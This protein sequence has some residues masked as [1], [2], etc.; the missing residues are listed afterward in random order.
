MGSTK[1]VLYP[2]LLL[3]RSGPDPCMSD[4][5]DGDRSDAW[6][7][8]SVTRKEPMMLII[9][10]IVLLLVAGG[11]GGY[12]LGNPGYDYRYGGGGIGLVLLIV[13]VLYL[14]GVLRF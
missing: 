1:H 2:P 7:T 3:H 14:V 13:L 8:A 6:R 12:Y 9:L 11:G 5:N 10:I 4:R